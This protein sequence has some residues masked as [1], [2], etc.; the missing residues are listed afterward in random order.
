MIMQMH[1][2]NNRFKIVGYLVA[3]EMRHTL[4]AI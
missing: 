4:M 3:E 2:M 1:F